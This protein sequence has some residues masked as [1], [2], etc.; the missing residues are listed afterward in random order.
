MSGSLTAATSGC[1]LLGAMAVGSITALGGGTIRDAVI[2]R[3]VPFWVEEWEYIVMAALA[4]GGVFFLWGNLEPGREVLPGLV[5]KRADGGEGNLMALGDALGLGAFAAVGAMN[6]IRAAAPPLVSAIC[7]LSTCTFGG[8]MRDTLLNR[9]VRIL[10]SYSDMYA[11]IAFGGAVGYLGL[12][13]LAPAAQGLR[14][15]ACVSGVVGAR[16]MAWNDDWRLPYWKGKTVVH[17]DLDPRKKQ[18]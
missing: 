5:L 14:I 4:A 9:P 16:Y 7:G 13:A 12:R 1:D 3:V 2:L 11:T 6:G 17:S 8:V 18:K 15:A 10:H